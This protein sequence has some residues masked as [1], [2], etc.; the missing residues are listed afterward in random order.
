MVQDSAECERRQD[1]KYQD[2][3]PS[4]RGHDDVR[5]LAKRDGLLN[6]L[7]ASHDEGTPE[8]H[9]GPEGIKLILDLNSQFSGR[10]QYQGIQ[11]RVILQQRLEDGESE[12]GCLS[13]ARLGDTNDVPT[14]QGDRDRLLLDGG[15]FCVAKAFAGFAEDVDNSLLE[16]AGNTMGDTGRTHQFFER[17]GW[18]SD[19]LVCRWWL[20][21]DGCRLGLG[22]E[23]AVCRCHCRCRC[24]CRR[25]GC[26]LLRLLLLLLC[27]G[28]GG[29]RWLRQGD[30]C[31]LIFAVVGVLAADS[32]AFAGLASLSGLA[33]FCRGHLVFLL[34]LDSHSVAALGLPGTCCGQSCRDCR[35]GGGSVGALE[36]ELIRS[37]NLGL[38]A[39][40]RGRDRITQPTSPF[41][42]AN[43]P[44]H[45]AF[46][47]HS[48]VGPAR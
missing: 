8:P 44:A 6:L 48:P 14:C 47:V 23:G 43:T 36:V 17:L 13:G 18:G 3:L 20:V 41:S 12:G 26:G 29:N 32:P 4:G 11:R 30:H 25:L 39:G 35:G 2:D 42:G 46:S 33:G 19:I 15:S 37:Q 1:V 21:V 22:A 5:L 24:W 31:A 34:A 7:H 10:G 28:R 27:R 16:L 38:I 45:M 40:G 9:D